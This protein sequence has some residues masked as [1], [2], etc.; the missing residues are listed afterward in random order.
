MSTR[1]SIPIVT[2]TNRHGNVNENNNN[3]IRTYGYVSRMHRDLLVKKMMIY[4]K[5]LMS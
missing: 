1:R 5:K 4:Y 3:T 2:R